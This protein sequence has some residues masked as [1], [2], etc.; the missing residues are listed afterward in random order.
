MQSAS[1]PNISSCQT[2]FSP[3]DAK[4]LKYSSLSVYAKRN[5]SLILEELASYLHILIVLDVSIS[6]LI[7]HDVSECEPGYQ[8]KM[9][10]DFMSGCIVKSKGCVTH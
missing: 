10:Q 7:R 4:K 5:L 6:S 3:A 8:K 1:F 2:G 9:D